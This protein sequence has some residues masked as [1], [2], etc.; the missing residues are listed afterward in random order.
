MDRYL[1]SDYLSELFNFDH[2]FVQYNETLKVHQNAPFDS[3]AGTSTPTKKAVYSTLHLLQFDANDKTK[4][5]GYGCSW[6]Y[7]LNGN[8][9]AS[10]VSTLKTVEQLT[11]GY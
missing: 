1:S 4:F 11:T 6:Y 5:T 9:T 7:S 10:L 2:Y 3:K 8:G